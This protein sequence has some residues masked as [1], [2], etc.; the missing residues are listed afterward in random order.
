VVRNQMGDRTADGTANA[1]YADAS[2]AEDSEKTCNAV[3]GDWRRRQRAFLSVF[4][5][6]GCF[7]IRQ[8]RP[9]LTA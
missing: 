6:R 5:V 9:G 7:V 2:D 1:E 4:S 3:W 8:G